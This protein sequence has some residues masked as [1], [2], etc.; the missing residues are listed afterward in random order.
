MSDPAHPDRPDHEDFWKLSRAVIANDDAVENQPTQLSGL[1]ALSARIAEFVDPDSAW[2]MAKQRIG[3]FIQGLGRER[4]LTEDGVDAIA[5]AAWI[6]GFMAACAAE[7][8]R[9]IF[10]VDG[11]HRERKTR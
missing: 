8:I 7:D 9:T 3:K 11:Q 10:T 5:R 2:Y 4:T 6:D 1:D